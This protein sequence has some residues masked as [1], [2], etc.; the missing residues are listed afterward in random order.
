MKNGTNFPDAIYPTRRCANEV[1]VK[2]VDVIEACANSTEGL[3]NKIWKLGPSYLILNII[4]IQF[5]GSKLLQKNGEMTLNF[6][7]PLKEVPTITLKQL[8]DGKVQASALTNLHGAICK[9]LVTKPKECMGA[10][11]G[12]ASLTSTVLSVVAAGL[13]VIRA[14]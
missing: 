10:D 13:V 7:N 1:K 12:V 8:Y 9:M 4:F 14:F 5:P 2:N 11:S 6:M 3:Y